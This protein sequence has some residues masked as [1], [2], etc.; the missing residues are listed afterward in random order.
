MAKSYSMQRDV[1][2]VCTKEVVQSMQIPE[3]EIPETRSA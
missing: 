2:R 1:I 3:M